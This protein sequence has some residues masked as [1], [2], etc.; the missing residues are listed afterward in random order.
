MGRF[1]SLSE[2]EY[3]SR[4]WIIQEVGLARRPIAHWGQATINFHKI[5]ITAM[6]ALQYFWSKLNSQ[7]FLESIRQVS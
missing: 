6:I 1:V 2:S 3:F 5:G 4:T 7:E